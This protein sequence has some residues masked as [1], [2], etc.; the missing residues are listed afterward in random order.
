VAL[1]L[2]LLPLVAATD[3]LLRGGPADPAVVMLA[4]KP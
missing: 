2:A 1:A 4:A 3:A